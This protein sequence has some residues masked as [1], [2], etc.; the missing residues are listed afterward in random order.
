[1]TF[2]SVFILSQF[3]ES[4]WREKKSFTAN[5]AQGGENNADPFFINYKIRHICITFLLIWLNTCSGCLKL[6]TTDNVFFSKM[7]LTPC[8]KVLKA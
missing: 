5:F 6:T 7:C 2:L 1:M 4:F 8:K 3:G